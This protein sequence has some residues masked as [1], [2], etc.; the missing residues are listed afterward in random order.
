MC[1][2]DFSLKLL[3]FGVEISCAIVLHKLVNYCEVFEVMSNVNQ[4][5]FGVT[6]EGYPLEP[7]GMWS[8]VSETFGVVEW[9]L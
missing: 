6:F 3:N 4:V 2:Q 9:S 5:Y 8:M 1:T 7:K